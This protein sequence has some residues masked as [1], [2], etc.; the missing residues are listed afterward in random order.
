MKRTVIA[1]GTVAAPYGV[2]RAHVVIEGERV[3]ALADDDGALTGADEVV[4]ADGLHV[5]P[6]AVD[7]HVHYEDLGHAERED[8]A[9]GTMA[10]AAGGIT[11]IVEHPLTIPLPITAQAFAEKRDRVRELAV[12]DFGLWGALTRPSLPEIPGEWREGARGFK[13]FMPFS[14]PEYPNVDD[15]ELL[16]GMEI[17]AGLDGL[18]LV[19]AEND[20]M[21]RANHARL[22]A[23][24]RRDPLAH[25]EGR[26]PLVEEEAV[27][28]AIFLAQQ[29]GVRLQVVHVSSPVS[30]E[31]VAGAKAR[32]QR[33]TMEVCSHHLLLDLDDLVRLG[34]YGRCAPALRDRALVERLWDHV[35]S[36]NADCLISDHAPYTRE[37]KEPGWEDIFAAPLGLQ[38]IQ[39][40]VPAV[41]SEA[42]HVR[43]MPLDAFVR[44]AS[45]NAARIVGLF[46]RKGTI[47]PGSDADIVLWDL[48]A[49]WT[50][51]S[52]SQQFSKN[53]W[54]PFDGRTVRGRVVRTLVRGETVY[55]DGEIRVEPGHGRFLPGAGALV[56]AAAS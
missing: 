52:A 28:R 18:V 32:A 5:L 36:G 48:D 40:T 45:T 51:D 15:A 56:P 21:M 31:L 44:F 41:L 14:E 39:E 49:E 10:A 12:V 26:P 30:A 17:V 6:G 11:T 53:P 34:P 38:N 47:L 4:D 43:G 3:V 20:A 2:F 9:T 25:H 1:N 55:V 29:A 24:G 54:S 19:H 16:A 22:Q 8:Y 46:P 27:H 35:L 42:L 50:V 33:V 13:A 7:P 23:D 37:E